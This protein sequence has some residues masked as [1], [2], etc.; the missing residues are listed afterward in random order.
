VDLHV[1]SGVYQVTYNN[2][3]TAAVGADVRYF[4]AQGNL[5][6]GGGIDLT[7]VAGGQNLPYTLVVNGIVV[8]AN[9]TL[10][11]YNAGIGPPTG[12]TG[13]ISSISIQETSSILAAPPSKGMILVG[14]MN[15][16]C[17]KWNGVCVKTIA[18]IK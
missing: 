6:G 16:S 10:S 5:I 12:G 14:D 1:P 8:G 13:D 15:T 2:G 18:S 17:V 9:N 3:T 11:F 4:Y 7:S